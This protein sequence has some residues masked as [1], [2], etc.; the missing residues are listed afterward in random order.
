MPL[1]FGPKKKW[2][3]ERP[4]YWR[5]GHYGCQ[6]PAE[7]PNYHLRNAHDVRFHPSYNLETKT[8]GSGVYRESETKVK[9]YTQ[10]PWQRF[11]LYLKLCTLG[12]WRL[13]THDVWL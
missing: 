3:G 1:T 8:V 13:L 4:W 11:W 10:T 12:W 7:F 9:V 2:G 5:F 6:C